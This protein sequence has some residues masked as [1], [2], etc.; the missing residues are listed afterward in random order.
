MVYRNKKQQEATNA[1]RLG[2]GLF[3]VCLETRWL[4]H[5]GGFYVQEP[6]CT[7]LHARSSCFSITLFI[8]C[9]K[10]SLTI[11]VTQTLTYALFTCVCLFLYHRVFL[12][13]VCVLTR[14]KSLSRALFDYLSFAHTHTL[15]LSLL[16]PS[17]KWRK[18]ISVTGSLCWPS[19]SDTHR[20]T[21]R[22]LHQRG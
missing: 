1:G 15:S 8:L 20:Q 5:F 11:S 19:A 13:C 2:A 4:G 9:L 6:Y 3:H 7:C 16:E 12:E 10:H 17:R 18:R 22:G 14:T 21:G